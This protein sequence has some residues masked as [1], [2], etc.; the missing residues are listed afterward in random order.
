M[1]SIKNLSKV[2]G[3]GKKAVDNISL[4]V[5][6]GE[7]IAFIGTSGSGKTTAL[8]MI[9][10]MIEATEGQITIN[11]K[12]V[13][14]MNPVEL[15]RKI[16]YVIQQIGL[17]P[18]M[19]IRENIVLVPKLLKWSEE[20]K[21][22]KAKE[23]IKLVDLPEE[24]LD[25]YPS[26]LSGGQQQRIGVVRA[27]AAEQDVILMDEPF[28][29]LD[30][31]TRDTLQDLVKELQQKL[32][33]TFIFVT[34]DMD[35]AIKLADKICIMS[36]GQVIQ[37]DTPDNILRHPANDFVRDFIGQNRLIQDRPNMRTVKDAMIKPVTVH[38]D[39]T[40]NEAVEI[41]RARRVDTIFV[42]G[43]N[44]KLLGYLDIEDI[45]QG[46]RTHKDLIDMMQR[47]IYRVRI[48]SKLQDSVRTILKRNVRNVPVV[49]SDGK[50]LI[51][52]VTRA[53]LVDIVYDSIWGE[54]DEDASAT[55]AAI[56][57]PDNVG[58]DI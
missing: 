35:E 58:A 57:E 32:G 56:V 36:E 45:N 5:E 15:R 31:I 1:L 10:R 48:D 19:T 37:Y 23:L 28:G 43:N 46:L 16:G 44:S 33:K 38:A 9:N 39:S 55:E 50:T 26:Q 51:G 17:M 27:L 7:F 40:L 24:F 4:E 11:G 41:M 29:A 53:N 47:D 18:H 42:V 3:G 20:K 54:L 14:K 49:D 13:R 12:D 34:H 25:R 21:E 52:L 8:R 22:K 2:Y 30:P 6:S